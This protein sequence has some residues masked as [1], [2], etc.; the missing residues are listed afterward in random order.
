MKI[1]S[2][3][4]I[5]VLANQRRGVCTLVTRNPSIHWVGRTLTIFCVALS[6]HNKKPTNWSI[7]AN[8]RAIKSR[9]KPV[10]GGSIVGRLFELPYCRLEEAGDVMSGVAADQAGVDVGV[11]FGDSRANS[12]SDSIRAAAHFVM[13]ERT[14]VDAGSR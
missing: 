3:H 12:S 1:Y 2:A 10:G 9:Q 11:K 7:K 14:M 8:R 13:D 4:T 6:K 5:I